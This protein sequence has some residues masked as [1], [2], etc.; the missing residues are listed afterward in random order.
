MLSSCRLLLLL[1]LFVLSSSR[2]QSQRLEFAPGAQYDAAVP[3][4]KTV[5][6]R[7]FGEHV[8]PPETILRYLRAL[9]EGAP[10]R[11][12]LIPYA[13]SWEGR[14]LVALVIGAPERMRELD[15]IR[16][17]LQRLANPAALAAGELD[18]LIA[19][20][21]VATKSPPPKRPWPKPITC[22]P[23]KTTLMWT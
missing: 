6:G 2:A 11:T 13:R 22:W 8:T 15:A 18:S 19:R 9:H 14:E 10:E 21:P 3:T 12:R 17:G 23:R 1:S 16:S 5:A 7:D 20:L 4:F